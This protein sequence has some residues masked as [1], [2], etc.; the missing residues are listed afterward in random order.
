MARKSAL[1]AAL[2]SHKQRSYQLEKQKKLEKQAAKRKRTTR[3]P[4]GQELENGSSNADQ[5][6]LNEAILGAK[7]QTKKL[8][9]QGSE[10]VP[11]GIETSQI[12]DTSSESVDDASLTFNHKKI[13]SGSESLEDHD[14]S[15]GENDIPLSDVDSLPSE[16][17]A[18]IVPYQRLTIN[19]MSALR[20][21]EKSIALPMPTLAFSEHQTILA[22]SDPAIA[23]VNDDLNRE[24]AF[25]KQCLDAAAEARILLRRE[26]VLFTR[27]SDYFA[28]M[29]K[30]DEH[31]GK[32]KS[33]MAEEAAGRKA[34]AEARKQ[35][36][37]KKFGKQVQVEKL[38]ERDKAKR[39]T[40]EKINSLKR[41]R[42][43][44]GGGDVRED[45]LF[46]VTLED[47]SRHDKVR[48][49]SKTA[50]GAPN[51]KRQRKDAKF[52]FG[53]KKRFAK[54]GDAMSTAD[55]R[56]FSSKR[57]KEQSKGP[58]R[59]GKGRRAKARQ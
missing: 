48:Q 53:G 33:K 38:Q 17:K 14:P 3:V 37:L 46:D 43:G 51:A 6:G 42:K 2:D 56:G 47:A 45:D 29:V 31:M 34:A 13:V 20:K 57:M 49:E 32:I 58:R 50:I 26:G 16:E 54:S 21:A 18:D 30:T 25:Y 8:E 35:R 15:D 59:L 27:P 19:N 52:G 23:D 36:D 44:T 41:K 7:L 55:I 24:L 12:D 1:L 40:L 28:E 4:T 9:A 39:E 5:T 11:Q 10:D 22:S